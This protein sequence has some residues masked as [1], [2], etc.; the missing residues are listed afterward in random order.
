MA[1]IFTDE[2]IAK[3]FESLEFNWEHSENNLLLNIATKDF[4]EAMWVV[5]EVAQAAEELNHHPDI[6][7]HD[8]NKLDI[9]TSTHSAGGITE[10]D[11]TLAER[12]EGIVTR[13]KN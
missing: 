3:R 12:V 11:F 7:L 4:T 13:I 8:Y 10:K 2:Q 6:F 5:N 9:T 1:K